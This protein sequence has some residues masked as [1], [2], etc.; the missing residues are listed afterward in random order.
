M[1]EID[2]GYKC[3]FMRK[4]I[5]KNETDWRELHSHGTVALVKYEGT[6]PPGYELEQLKCSECGRIYLRI[7][8]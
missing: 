8:K 5:V 3:Q 7:K 6:Q 1:S 2:N 4:A